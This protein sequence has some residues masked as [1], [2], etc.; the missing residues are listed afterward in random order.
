M[1][2]YEKELIIRRICAGHV[3]CRV[4]GETWLLTPPSRNQLYEAQEIFAD[5]LADA[6]ED[7]LYTDAELLDFL[8]DNHLWDTERSKLLA[9]LPEEI[10]EFK[11]G[12][13]KSSFKSNEKKAI[14]RAIRTAEAKLEELHEQRHAYDHLSTTGYATLIR[15]RFL[16]WVGLRKENESE[17]FWKATGDFIDEVMRAA[18]QKRIAEEEYREVSRSEPWRSLWGSHKAEGSLFGVAAVDYTEEQ[19]SLVGWSMLYDNVFEHPE[20]PADAVI[21]DD[22]VLDGWLIHQRRE[23]EKRQK[24]TRSETATSDKIKN[25]DEVYFPANNVEE[26]REI[27]ELND[28]VAKANKRKR[29]AKLKEKGQLQDHQMPD[30]RQRLRMELANMQRNRVTNG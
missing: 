3:R 12:L 15:A 14:R 19:R 21:N 27:N 4:R 29:F 1:E 6:E 24:E 2:S 11:L 18:A 23:R 28:E 22:D 20:C 8:L 10:E 9:K 25:A 16:T 5:A 26:A 7:G 17:A 13:F 30:Q